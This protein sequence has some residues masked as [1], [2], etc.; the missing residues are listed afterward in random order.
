MSVPNWWETLLLLAAAY[1]F[2]RLLSFDTITERPRTWVL[3]RIA[4]NKKRD[5]YWGI[6]LT[7]PWCAGAWITAAALAAYCAVYG[8]IGWFNFGAHWF[9]MSLAVGLIG[10][11][12][13]TE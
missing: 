13:D 5:D 12:V 10:S 2:W 7:C 8:W 1:R 4:D 6:F 3:E 9:A 11:K